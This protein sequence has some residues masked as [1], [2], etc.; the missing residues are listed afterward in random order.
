MK[1]AGADKTVD[2]VAEEFKG[3][4]GA[5]VVGETEAVNEKSWLLIDETENPVYE[6]GKYF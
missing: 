4:S 6:K 2:K 1:G 5:G 3:P